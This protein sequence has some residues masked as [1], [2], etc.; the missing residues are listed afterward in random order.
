M[1]D[2]DLEHLAEKAGIAVDWVDYA[3]MPR[4][5]APPTLR[6]MLQALGLPCGSPADLKDSLHR[7]D[8]P[9]LPA[10]VTADIGT[11][12][13]VPGLT[14][15]R[16]KLI[17]EDGTE[18][19]IGIE[20]GRLSAILTEPG[21]HW[22]VT[23]AGTI[24]VIAAP[25]TCFR[26]RD[27]TAS[28]LTGLAAQI[29]GL[30]HDGDW[31]IG[32]MAGV[33]ALARAAAPLGVDALGLSPVHALFTSDPSHFGPYSPSSRLFLNP[34][35]ADPAG[36]LGPEL[37]AEALAR[38]GLPE[39][40]TALPPALIDWPASAGAKL[41]WLRALSDIVATRNDDDPI[42]RDIAAFRQDGGTLLE[43]HA[44]FEAMH[45]ARRAFDEADGD[46]RFWPEDLRSPDH[47]AVAHFVES[48]AAEI[49]Y[50]VFLQYLADRS[51]ARAQV[52]AIEAGMRIG[53][54]SD[55]AVGMT[56][57]G[58]HAWSR[59]GD[60]LVGLTIGAP[61]DLYNGDG[62][63]WGLTSFSP[64]ALQA[65]SFEPFAATLQ[66]AMRH[67][68][69]VRIDHVMGLKR[70]WL[71]PEGMPAAE[72]AYL[73][74]PFQDMMRVVALESMRQRAVVVAE[75]LGRVPEGFRAGLAARGV[76]GMNVLWF[77][78]NAHR[79]LSAGRWPKTS[80]AM[81]STH[82]LP[83][84]A[85]WWSGHDIEVK[86]G[87][88]P[89]DKKTRASQEDARRADR[90][91]LWDTL[92]PETPM[93]EAEA[94]D[95]FVDAALGFVA[96]TPAPL[97]LFPLEDLLGLKDQPNL[98][99]TIDEHPNWRRRLPRDAGTLLDD[100]SVHRRLAAIRK[101]R[102]GP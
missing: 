65:A 11:L 7:L 85:G 22:L 47:P 41:R 28:R 74:Y 38:A 30:G 79:F 31:G 27:I 12:L 60:I 10:T 45:A 70:L 66:A 6:R 87:L 88:K 84:L 56:P 71:V 75:D 8:A 62:Q 51:M 26:I 46:W 77:E 15:K 59:Q 39:T 89:A 25:K 43:N 97:A 44:C 9:A 32:D 83:T 20:D 102:S 3:D 54:V 14:G 91:L 90:A 19:D 101:A 5:V 81:T 53:L 42:R 18:R 24:Q 96:T 95:A 86:A 16:A 17:L 94:T 21:R 40:H 73:T 78:R 36:V 23:E 67:A 52:A 37:A 76:L 61:P 100:P 1:R 93:P 2:G 35:H 80:A 64:Q 49:D 99:G 48:Q 50:H 34:L 63:N 57:A 33:A 13:A 72:G 98:P 69:G 92:A 55:L 29:Y 68:G 4:K 82:D 58:S